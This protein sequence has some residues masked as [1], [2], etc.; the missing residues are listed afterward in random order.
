[1]DGILSVVYRT[2]TCSL[3][4]LAE[5]VTLVSYAKTCRR[6]GATLA[7]QDTRYMGTRYS[8]ALDL[9]APFTHDVAYASGGH[10]FFRLLP[11][12]APILPGI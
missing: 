6:R 5:H 10:A 8:L 2:A 3:G 11:S 12:V 9:D 1:M 7:V 4:L